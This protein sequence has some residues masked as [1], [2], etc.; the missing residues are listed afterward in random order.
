MKGCVGFHRRF[1]GEKYRDAL[2]AASLL[3]KCDL[4]ERL[5]E[6]G[7]DVLC[8]DKEEVFSN[9]KELI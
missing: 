3:W 1:P 6:I 7:E 5:W 2:C 9:N 4:A 8:A